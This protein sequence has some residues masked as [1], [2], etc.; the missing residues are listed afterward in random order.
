VVPACS[1]AYEQIAAANVRHDGNPTLTDHVESAVQ[2]TSDVGWGLSKGRPRRKIDAAI[3]LVMALSRAHAGQHA[4][5]NL[6]DS[7]R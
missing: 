4:D 6:L 1:L 2:R 7:V 3:A 5:Y